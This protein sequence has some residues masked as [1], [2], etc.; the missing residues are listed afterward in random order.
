MSKKPIQPME[1]KMKNFCANFLV[2]CIG[3]GVAAFILALYIA[4]PVTIVG[5]IV[6]VSLKVLQAGG[7]F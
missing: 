5:L 4:V 1:V 7:V 2:G 6:F 3:V